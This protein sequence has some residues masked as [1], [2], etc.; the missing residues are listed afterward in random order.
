MK[1]HLSIRIFPKTGDSHIREF[2]LFGLYDERKFRLI[3]K[4]IVIEFTDSGARRPVP[5][6]KISRN[7]SLRDELIG[8][9]QPVDDFECRRVSRRGARAV[10]DDRFGFKQRD[11]ESFLSRGE[12]SD[13]TN[14]SRTDDD[15]AQH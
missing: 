10:V 11:G 5:E 8:Q 14:R 7:K 3:A 6:L 1:P 9:S 15:D 12:C 2:V 4:K 13:H